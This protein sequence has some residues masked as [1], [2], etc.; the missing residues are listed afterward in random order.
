VPDEPNLIRI[1]ADE[2]DAA[3]RAFRA[4]LTRCGGCGECERLAGHVK[5]TADQHELLCG[6]PVKTGAL[7]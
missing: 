7:W 3:D 4:H 1:A 5:R 6:G 2:R